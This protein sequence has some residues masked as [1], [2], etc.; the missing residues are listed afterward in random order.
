ML[1][2]GYI[3][4]FSDTGTVY[5]TVC[6]NFDERGKGSRGSVL[7]QSDVMRKKKNKVSGWCGESM[8]HRQKGR[9]NRRNVDL[10]V[11]FMIQNIRSITGNTKSESLPRRP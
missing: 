5:L 8:A 6:V 10:E 4:Q 2:P 11:I 1:S 9:N 3:C 7:E